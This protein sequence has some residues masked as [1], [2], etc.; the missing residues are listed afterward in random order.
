[1]A[2]A[3]EATERN[4]RRAAQD[5]RLVEALAAGATQV[6]AGKSAGVNERTVRRRLEEPEFVARVRTRR[7]ETLSQAAGKMT[8]LL[9]DAVEA[10]GELV[11]IADPSVRLRA[12]TAI[13]RMAD[14]FQQQDL[15][16][17]QEE[18]AAQL[19]ELEARHSGEPIL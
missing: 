10:L 18:I 3:A 12:A 2:D 4:T 5:D 17:R 15:A 13:V 9:D 7:H 19:A 6:D 1:M 14:T 11:R 8:S 16:E